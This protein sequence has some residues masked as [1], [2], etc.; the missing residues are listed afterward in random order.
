DGPAV[1]G[2]AVQ[3]LREGR[4]ALEDA[5]LY[6]LPGHP[7]GGVA[8][9]LVRLL[10][11]RCG[12]K[13]LPADAV[14]GLDDPPGILWCTA[15]DAGG[16]ISRLHTTPAGEPGPAVELFA[17]ATPTDEL[18]E[19]LRRSV[20]DGIPWDRIEIVATDPR[21]YGAALDALAR[22]LGIPVTYSTGLDVRRTRVGRAAE[23]YLDWISE[24]F[25]AD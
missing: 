8:G 17:A 9:R 19:V 10:I 16:A 7:L 13:I 24:G 23:A 3:A 5:A 25:P 11:E 6:L 18:R 14:I 15:G 2:A 21:L 1:L 12:A 20:A 22:R 4:A